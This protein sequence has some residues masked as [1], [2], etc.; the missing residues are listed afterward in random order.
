MHKALMYDIEPGQVYFV[1]SPNFFREKGWHASEAARTDIYELPRDEQHAAAAE[2][3]RWRWHV[4]CPLGT[5][6]LVIGAPGSS[7]ACKN[8][9]RLNGDEAATYVPCMVTLPNGD[10]RFATVHTCCLWPVDPRKELCPT[11]HEQ[12]I[13]KACFSSTYGKQ[14]FERHLEPSEILG[15]FSG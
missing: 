14:T 1:A 12:G 3:D 6:A 5:M 15:A 13:I 9:A 2:G 11:A 4:D 8:L 10:N 7:E